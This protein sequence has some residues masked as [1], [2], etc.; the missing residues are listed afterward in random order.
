MRDKARTLF[1]TIFLVINIGIIILYLLVCLVPFINTGDFWFVAFPGLAFPLIFFALVC[2]II[3]WAILK[4]R[5]AWV[6]LIVLLLG[7]QQVFA[8]FALHL[9]RNFSAVKQ[10]NMLRIFHWNVEG[11]DDYFGNNTNNADSYYPKMIQLI[12]PQNAD[13]LCFEEYTDEKNMDDPGSVTS[14]IKDLGYPYH[15]F[16]KT[17]AAAH[18][19]SGVIIFSKYPIINSDTINFGQ[20][21]KAEHLIYID[22]KRGKKTLRIFTTH[23][24]SVRFD[25]TQYASLNKL[26]HAKDPGY[27]DSRTIISKL[28]TGYEYRYAQAGIVKKQIEESPYPAIITGDFNDVPNSNTYFTIKGRLQ[29][30][31]LK[32]GSLIGRTFRFISPTLRIDYILADKKFKVNQFRVIHVP[33]SDHYPIEADLQY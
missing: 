31:F 6:S 4:S 25:H 27:R 23:L 12:K 2:F 10:P 13:I 22:I 11:W 33:Y 9:P 17:E 19:V 28:K 1:R 24:Q 21:T 20:N 26:K 32:K 5:W 8:V 3:F 30:S 16:A 14:A 15:L 29:D 7:C 18:T